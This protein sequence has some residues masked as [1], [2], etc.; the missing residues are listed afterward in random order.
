MPALASEVE[1]ARRER[2]QF[3]FQTIPV[4]ILGDDRVRGLVA[5]K[6]ELGEPDASGRLCP[7]PVPGSE[8]TLEVDLVIP[9][10]G[11]TADFSFF[12]P[13]WPLRRHPG[14]AAR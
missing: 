3:H 1:E 13:G 6:T 9:A 7:M 11:Q 2:V 5:Q 4:R 10:V 12:G 14:G 8:F